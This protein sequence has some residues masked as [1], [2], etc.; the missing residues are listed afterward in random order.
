MG[1]CR[2]GGPSSWSAEQLP[3]SDVLHVAVPARAMAAR[4]AGRTTEASI[5]ELWTSSAALR[6]TR[7]RDASELWGFCKTCYYAD[8]CKA[9]CSWVTHAVLGRRGNNPFCYH[10]AVSLRKKGIAEKLRIVERAPGEPYDLARFELVE[11]PFVAE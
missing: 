8:T 4:A 5:D 10:R 9:G 7:D 11:Q 1:A 2:V 3:P 6:F